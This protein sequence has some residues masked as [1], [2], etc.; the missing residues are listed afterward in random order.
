MRLGGA[1]AHGHSS[2]IHQPKSDNL[3]LSA[4]EWV[5]KVWSGHAVEH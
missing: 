4:Q 3:C 5:D 1:V 2:T